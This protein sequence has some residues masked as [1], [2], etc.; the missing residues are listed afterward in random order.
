MM[1][2]ARIRQVVLQMKVFN[3][4]Y[5]ILSRKR[6]MDF[7]SQM[8]CAKKLISSHPRL[9]CA[10]KL[11]PLHP[12]MLCVKFGWNWPSGSWEEDKDIKKFTD[13][14][15]DTQ[16]DDDKLIW[17]FSSG[18]LKRVKPNIGMLVL[19]SWWLGPW[20]LSN[21]MIYTLLPSLFCKDIDIHVPWVL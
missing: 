17:A 15:T 2:C 10:Q 11:N 16:T 18:E 20:K 4:V 13:R 19:V 14:W 21:N 9:L 1:L 6:G 8:V 3:C 12:G 5:G 7:H